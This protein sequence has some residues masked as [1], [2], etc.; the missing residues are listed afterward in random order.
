MAIQ[1][2]A[3]MQQNYLLQFDHISFIVKNPPF[4]HCSKIIS[5]YTGNLY[6]FFGSS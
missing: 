6:A 3:Q 2:Q 5:I 4:I 1:L